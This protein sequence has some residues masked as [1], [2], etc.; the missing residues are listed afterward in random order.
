MNHSKLDLEYVIN[1]GDDDDG[2]SSRN[3]AVVDNE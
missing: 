3:V 1:G 2:R